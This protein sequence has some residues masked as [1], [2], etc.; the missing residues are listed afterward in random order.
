MKVKM[1]F[2][3]AKPNPRTDKTFK[4]QP[5]QMLMKECDEWSKAK[6]KDLKSSVEN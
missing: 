4:Q 6:R 5:R 1:K 3:N 2:E